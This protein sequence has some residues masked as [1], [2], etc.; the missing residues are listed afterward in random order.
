[1]PGISDMPTTTL[2]VR[3]A[4]RRVVRSAYALGASAGGPGVTPAQAAARRALSRF[5]AS[6]PH[7][8]T[9]RVYVPRALAV[10]AGPFRGQPQAGA[11]RRAW[12][13]ASD[14]ATAGRRRP[15]GFEYRCL[16]VRGAAARTLL[17]ALARGNEQTRW[18]VRSHRAQSYQLVVRPLLPDE[19]GCAALAR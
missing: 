9:A 19:S 1:M 14:L 17:A 2:V 11:P 10:Y 8:R 12:P 3:A 7:G 13:L 6:L 16:T 4:G 18:Y 5:V 15:S